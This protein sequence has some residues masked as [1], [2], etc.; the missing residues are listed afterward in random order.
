MSVHKSHC[1]IF[2]AAVSATTRETTQR[3]LTNCAHN[4]VDYTILTKDKKSWQKSEFCAHHNVQFS[5]LPDW[6]SQQSHSTLQRWSS[7]F[8][9]LL[10]L[11]WNLGF[12]RKKDLVIGISN[13]YL[14]KPLYQMRLWFG[15]QLTQFVQEKFTPNASSGKGCCQSDRL[16][17]LPSLAEDIIKAIE[18]FQHAE[19]PEIQANH[20]AQIKFASLNAQEMIP[21]LSLSD[22]PSQ[23]QYNTPKL[24]WSASSDPNESFLDIIESLKTLSQQRAI[25]GAIC[26]RKKANAILHSQYEAMPMTPIKGIE[27]FEN[28]PYIDALRSQC[29]ILLISPNHL[30]VER[31]VLF[32]MAA[33]MCVVLPK[34]N[35]Y[36]DN[37]LTENIHCMKYQPQN[38]QS[39]VETI[40]ALLDD[41]DLI[42]QIGLNASELAQKIQGV[43]SYKTISRYI[44]QTLEPRDKTVVDTDI[45]KK[46]SGI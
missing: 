15:F 25:Q 29:N 39:L 38:L 43:D 46:R 2:D 31:D 3:A 9:L 16:F 18:C 37:Q 14:D 27:W 19:L 36:W 11:L 33:G 35:S 20:C 30:N 7:H 10:M 34:D 6:V 41:C 45:V 42:Y 44:N 1:L 5:L 13:P 40:N 24:F 26:F 22:W 32:A 28:A 4:H 21:D 12:R 8:I 23:C 17:Y